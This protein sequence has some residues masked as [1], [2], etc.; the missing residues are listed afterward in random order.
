M[1][2]IKSYIKEN[3]YLEDQHFIIEGPVSYSFLKTL[4]FDDGLNAF[5][6][7]NEQFEALLEITTLPEGRVYIIR[8]DQHI[9]GYVTYHYPDE[10]ERWSTGQLPYLIELGAIE[11]SKDYRHL[12]LGGRLI[13]IS[14]SAD[15]FEDYIVLT[16]EYYWHWDLKHAQLDVFEYKR[17]MQKLMQKGGLEVF[18][19]DD[20]EITSHPANCLM[21]RIGK[22]ISLDQQHAFDDIRFQNRFFY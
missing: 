17:L 5:R 2:H 12:H 7:Y 22:R 3:I 19:T 20:P 6:S 9:I 10:L 8:R 11:L 13:Q 18:A 16:T 4:T 1:Q 21:A 15:E 14:L